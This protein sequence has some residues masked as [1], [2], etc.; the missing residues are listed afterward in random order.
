MS[1]FAVVTYERVESVAVIRFN[2]TAY[3]NAQNSPM[4]HV[5]DDAIARAV[6][7]GEVGSTAPGGEGRNVWGAQDIGTPQRDVDRTFERRAVLWREHVGKNGMD[8]GLPASL[9]C[10]SARVDDGAKL[11]SPSRWCKVHA[12]P[13]AQCSRGAAIHRG[14]GRCVLLRSGRA[15]GDPGRRALRTS[16]LHKPTC[17]EELPLTGDRIG[18]SM[19]RA[20]PELATSR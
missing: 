13:A 2:R 15:D 17:R 7:D 18:R 9:R 16:I 14:V 20:R 3:A 1:E 5:L 6:N 4:T 10:T 19:A 8:D 12:S 11:P